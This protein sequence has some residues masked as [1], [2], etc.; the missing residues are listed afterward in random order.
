MSC[1]RLVNAIYTIDVGGVSVE[2]VSNVRMAVFNHF[3]NHYKATEVVHPRATDLHFR[4]LSIREWAAITKPFSME[5]LKNTV[6]DC[7]SYKCPSPDS[8]N[9]GFIKD[10]WLDM[11]EDLM[12]FVTDFHRNGKLLRGIN[13]TFITLIP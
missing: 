10:F 7:D 6:W 5:E 2:D 13:S 1:R 4:T 12:H 3:S 9:F 8:G 11:K